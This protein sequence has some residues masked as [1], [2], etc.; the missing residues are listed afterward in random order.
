MVIGLLILAV[1]N[2][3]F[4][5]AAGEPRRFGLREAPLAYA[6]EAAQ[7]AG[8]PGLPDRA[9]VFD[10]AQSGVYVFHNGPQRKVFMDGRL[11]V[12][13]RATFATYIRLENMLNEGRRG[14]AEP[15]RRMGNPSILLSHDKEYGGE[16]T[17]LGDPD[18][19]CVYFDAVASVFVAPGDRGLDDRFHAIDFA[20]RHFRDRAWQAIPPG[21]RGFAEASALLNVGSALRVR[22]GVTGRLPDSLMLCAGDRLRQA[23]AENP[24]AATHWAMLGR[25][26]WNMVPD[27]TAPPPGPRESWDPA[28]GILPAQ[29]TFCFRRALELDPADSA[30]SS[31]LLRSLEARQMHDA[32]QTVAPFL[33]QPRERSVDWPTCDRIATLLIHL[34]R[35]ADARLVWELA[36]DPPSPAIQ[37]SRTAAALLA[38]LDFPTARNTLDR[39]L[40]QDPQLGEAWFCLALLHV[41]QGAPAPALAACE[42]ALKQRLTTPQRTSIERFKALIESPR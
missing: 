28:R 19:R 20:A 18:W 25:S 40:A 3:R 23:I 21:P 11:E 24:T 16:A 6:H 37:Q 38:A 10:L 29:A 27:L 5:Q 4:D 1:V 15:I 12:P 8:Q 26:L 9:L 36:P 33:A 13:D 7:F 22:D 34:G 17:L 2:G 35:P 41:Q 32:E 30:T 42:T 39:A 31:A 14:W